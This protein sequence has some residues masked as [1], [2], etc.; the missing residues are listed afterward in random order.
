MEAER[1]LASSACAGQAQSG[2]YGAHGRETGELTRGETDWRGCVAMT[3]IRGGKCP[4]EEAE[5]PGHRGHGL[6]TSAAGAEPR[7]IMLPLISVALSLSRCLERGTRGVLGRLAWPCAAHAA[8]LPPKS[9][10]TDYA[11]MVKDSYLEMGDRTNH[12]W[13]T[14]LPTG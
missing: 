3:R 13:S 11:V 2:G 6:S 10:T 9:M 5:G 14:N 4:Y 7:I 1:L 8:G 12:T